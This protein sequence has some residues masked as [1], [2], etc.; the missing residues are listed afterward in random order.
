MAAALPDTALV[1]NW[2]DGARRGVGLDR[3]R[4]SVRAVIT[5]QHAV[6]RAAVG[7][8]PN[9]AQDGTAAL[10][11]HARAFKGMIG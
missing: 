2:V 4:S 5:G 8:D 11:V 10:D 6:V 9:A 3:I 1:L 7:E